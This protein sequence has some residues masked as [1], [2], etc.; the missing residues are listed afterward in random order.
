MSSF[1]DFYKSHIFKEN[2]EDRLIQI[3]FLINDVIGQMARTTSPTEWNRLLE[4]KELFEIERAELSDSI[5]R[6][7]I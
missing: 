4:Q 2:I 1:S 7:M 6:T 5:N 3:D